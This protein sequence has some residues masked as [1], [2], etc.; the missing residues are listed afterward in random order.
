[1]RVSGGTESMQKRRIRIERPSSQQS[2][3]QKL[4]EEVRKYA[5]LIPQEPEPNMG[6][7]QEIRDEIQKGTYLKP[8][9]IEETATRLAVRFLKKM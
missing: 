4:Q 6:R 8:E 9:M 2:A 5:R 3:D 1:M 7:V